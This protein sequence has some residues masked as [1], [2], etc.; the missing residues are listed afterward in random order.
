[1]KTEFSIADGIALQMNRPAL[2]NL[3]A[4]LYAAGKHPP[5]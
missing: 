5:A 3:R 1:M 4:I 2:Q